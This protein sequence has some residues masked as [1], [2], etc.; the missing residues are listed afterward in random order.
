MRFSPI[1]PPREFTVGPKGDIRLKDCAR[2]GLA[3]DEQVTFVTDGGAEY[4]VVKKSWG[5]YATPSLNRRLLKFGLRAALMKSQDGT[6]YVLLVEEDKVADFQNYCGQ[7]NMTLLLWLD[8]DPRLEALEGRSKGHRLRDAAVSPC[9]LCGGTDFSLA[10]SYEAPPEGETRFQL[11]GSQSYRRKMF[12]CNV[13]GHFV[14]VHDMNISALYTGEYVNST[15]GKDG[16]RRTFERIVALEAKESDNA[17]RVK[18]VR[19]FSATHFPASK[20]KD[21]SPSV[22]DVGSGLC[23]FSY[24]MKSAGWNC[25]ALDP[26]PRAMK[27]AREVVGVT[28]MCGDLLTVQGLGRY[29]AVTFNKVLEHVKDPV[30]LLEKSFEHLNNGGFVYVEVPDGEMAVVDGSGR[31]EFFIEHWHV[32]SSVSITLLAMRAGFSV[33]ALERLREPSGKYTLRAFLIP[34]RRLVPG[35]GEKE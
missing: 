28:A 32:F 11:P 14:S 5:F 7:Q 27:H 10:F 12:R 29:D 34:G 8:S 22:L 23:V 17:G 35:E 3:P 21:S 1:I 24:G 16:I 9:L 18:R 26:D 19:E 31:E 6:F 15:Y 30:R 4:D 2:I 20:M 25:T 13:C 33:W